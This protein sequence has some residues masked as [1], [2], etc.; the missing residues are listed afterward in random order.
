[1]LLCYLSST[2]LIL[3]SLTTVY[4]ILP[5]EYGN[6]IPHLLSRIIALYLVQLALEVVGRHFSPIDTWSR[7]YHS[8]ISIR[9]IKMTL[10]H[11]HENLIC[12]KSP[13]TCNNCFIDTQVAESIIEEFSDESTFEQLPELEFGII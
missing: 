11:A 3:R 9:S 5:H 2:I 8:T 13:L 1:M 12:I 10:C 6:T 7:D 4:D